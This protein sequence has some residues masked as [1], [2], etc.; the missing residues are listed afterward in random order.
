[1]NMRKI[2]SSEPRLNLCFV[3]CGS[4]CI[5]HSK[6]LKKTKYNVRL[7]F[8]SRTKEKSEALKKRFDGFKAFENY[9][10]AISD[11]LISVIFITTPPNSHYELAHLAL[12][13]NKHVIVEKPPFFSS[14]ELKTLGEIADKKNLQLLVAENYFYRPLRSQIKQLINAG[15]IGKPIYININAL[16]SQKSKNDWREDVEISK[17]GALFEGGIHWVNFINNIGLEIRNVRGF[18]HS[19][20]SPLEKSAQLNCQSTSG[21]FIN[22]QYS[23]EI[24][25]LLSGLRISKIYGTQGS[26]TFESNGIFIM[27]R[28][29][30][31]KFKIPKL[32][33]I[34]GFEPMYMDFLNSIRTN[35]KAQ[36]DWQMAMKD[37][38]LIENAYAS[39]K[40]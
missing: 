40:E 23:W 26:I 14:I 35:S 30:K 13:H 29:K 38:Q 3:G 22:L 24:D 36:F 20:L 39:A 18:T 33:H 6:R 15:I 16:K 21:S 27:V 12:K 11:P 34:T 8:A 37:L 2:N 19:N 1:M 9:N 31:W 17:Y 7:S 4:I 10:E 32:S 25:S 28:G 5:S